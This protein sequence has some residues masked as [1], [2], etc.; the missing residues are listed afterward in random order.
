MAET[1]GESAA[2]G[3]DQLAQA[4][5]KK[6]APETSGGDSVEQ[7]GK[8]I[9]RYDPHAEK[10]PLQAVLRPFAER[11]R[12]GK[13][14]PAENNVVV[15]NLP[16]AHDHDDHGECIDPVHDAHRQG[17]KPQAIPGI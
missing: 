12:I 6:L 4:D 5:R 8:P 11:D 3:G 10:M 7:V 17:M 9:E 16:S 1:K 14:Q 13:P 15:I 2:H